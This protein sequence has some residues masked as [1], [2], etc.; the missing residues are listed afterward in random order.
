MFFTILMSV[1]LLVANVFFFR[2]SD[3]F[4]KSLQYAAGGQRSGKVIYHLLTL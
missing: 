1:I 2:F 4:R 3:G